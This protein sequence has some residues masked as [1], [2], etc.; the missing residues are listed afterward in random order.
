[1]SGPTYNRDGVPMSGKRAAREGWKESANPY[2]RN[3]T[4]ARRRWQSANAKELEKMYREFL[5]GT[6]QAGRDLGAEKKP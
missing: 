6:E 1:M 5:K 4:R 3:A 2:P